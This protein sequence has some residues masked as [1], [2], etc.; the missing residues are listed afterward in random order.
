MFILPDELELLR[1]MQPL[2]RDV[3]YYLAERCDFK[4]GI[5]G[6]VRK[7]SY[8][9]IAFDLTEHDGERRLKSSLQI[10]TARQVRNSVIRLIDSG[11]L[12]SLSGKG[13]QQLLILERVFFAN[14]LSLHN[15]VQIA[16]GKVLADQIACEIYFLYNLFNELQGNNQSRRQA[17]TE[18]DG[19]TSLYH[20]HQEIE[21]EMTPDWQ[22][23][24]NELAMLY[25]RAG[26]NPDVVNP[27]WITNFIGYWWSHPERKFSQRAWTYRF[28]SEMIRFV[29]NPSL[30]DSLR[31]KG[32]VK[33][34]TV[35]NEHIP[36]YKKIPKDDDKLVS[37]AQRYGFEGP[38]IG[39]SYQQFRVS[40]LRSVEKREAEERRKLS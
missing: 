31:G 4:T 14:L 13:K 23:E 15:S 20:H 36:D 6:N 33:T 28:A 26:V 39:Q 32:S 38:Q 10:L 35:G 12:R 9:G 29:R 3:F 1:T 18:P 2:D 22:P 21:F 30:F 17:K 27:A 24:C 40:L 34:R 25:H 11:L 5:T 37:W 8:G 19:I 7:V 16:D